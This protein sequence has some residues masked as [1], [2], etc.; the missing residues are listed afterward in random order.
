MFNIL[1]TLC[2]IAA[3]LVFVYNTLLPGQVSFHTYNV[4][5]ISELEILILVKK[6]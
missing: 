3:E 2:A 4:V 6:T 5:A 1:F